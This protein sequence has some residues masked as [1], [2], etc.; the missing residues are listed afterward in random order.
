MK[1][2]FKKQGNGQAIIILHGLFGMLDNWQ[3]IANELAKNFEV[4]LVDARNHGHS[5][6][7]ND[8]SYEV[9]AYDL[10]EFIKDHGILQPVIIGHSMGGKTAMWHAQLFAHEIKKLIVVDMGI[11]QYPVHHQQIIAALQAVDFHKIQSRKEAEE[12]M[13]PHISEPSIRQFLLK[14]LHRNTDGSYNWRFNLPVIAE[15]I[16]NVSVALPQIEVQVPTLFIRGELSNYIL[17]KD[18]SSISET[19]SNSEIK[20]IKNAGHWVHAEA[21]DEVVQLIIDFVNSM[22]SE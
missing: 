11:K 15:K 5:P 10:H 19:F 4:W 12:S 14:S 3:S 9:M 2:H 6:H 17:E 20:S 16:T 18:Y 21:S 22:I 1:L 8:F 13:M 7:S